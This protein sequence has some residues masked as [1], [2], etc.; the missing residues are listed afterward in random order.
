MIKTELGDRVASRTNGERRSR[1]VLWLIAA[2]I[3]FAV[4][5][6]IDWP[7]LVLIG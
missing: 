3:T 6:S 7:T 4:V 5:S 2:A 1:A